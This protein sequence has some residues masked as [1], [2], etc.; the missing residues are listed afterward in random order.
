[1]VRCTQTKKGIEQT[2][3]LVT[4]AASHYPRALASVLS[5]VL[6]LRTTWLSGENRQRPFRNTMRNAMGLMAG[7]MGPISGREYEVLLY[8]QLQ[9]AN[10]LPRYP[11]LTPFFP[12][13]L[14]ILSPAIVQRPPLF[15]F[16][17]TMIRQE[18][19]KCSKKYRFIAITTMNTVNPG[20]D[21]VIHVTV[22]CGVLATVAVC[23]RFAAR[24]RSPAS[25][26]AD[27]WWMVAS[28]I[29]SYGMLAVGSI[30]MLLHSSISIMLT[31]RVITSGKGGQH[32]D[33]LTESQIA[34][35]LKVKR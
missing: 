27:D 24:W 31:N 20:R 2:L 25:F 4:A 23:L 18:V 12:M 19:D 26:A 34:T 21:R 28:L 14:R 15:S 7:M 35:F 9:A 11:F 33:T 22:A 1:M 10:L 32:A 29:P 8:I 30:S 5:L 13:S 17:L 16:H 6:Q 3:T